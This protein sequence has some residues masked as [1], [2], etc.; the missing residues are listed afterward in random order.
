MRCLEFGVGFGNLWARFPQSKT[1]LPKEP[2][3]LSNLQRYAM[4]STKLFGQGWSLP[5]LRRKADLGWRGSQGRLNFC[6]LTITQPTGTSRSL[7]LGQARQSVRFKSLNPV[8]DTAGRVPQQF[9]DFRAGYA[10]G[11]EEHSVESRVVARSVVAPDLILEGHNH[12]FFVG[13]AECFHQAEDS[14][15]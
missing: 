12:V 15:A 4:L 1:Q 9:G 6:Q 3:A 14:P 5:H 2:L 8:Y 7:S 13:D 10:L 11:N